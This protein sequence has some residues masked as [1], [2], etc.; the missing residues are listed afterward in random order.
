M[1]TP[2]PI[3]RQQPSADC[4]D[5]KLV[6]SSD[7]DNSPEPVIHAAAAGNAR[8]RFRSKAICLMRSASSGV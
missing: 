5:R 1:A 2:E 7:C 6:N 8:T 4:D 3:R